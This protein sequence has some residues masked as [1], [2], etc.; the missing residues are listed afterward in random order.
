[1]TK[2]LFNPQF[3]SIFRT[4]HN[5]TY[6][7]RRLCRFSDIYMTSISCLLNYDLSYTFYPRRTPLQHEAPLWMDQLCTGCMKTPHLEEMSHIRWGLRLLSLTVTVRILYFTPGKDVTMPEDVFPYRTMSFLEK[8]VLHSS[9]RTK[10]RSRSTLWPTSPM[11]S[12]EGAVDLA[13][14]HRACYAGRL[15]CLGTRVILKLLPQ[16]RRRGNAEQHWAADAHFTA[17]K[18]LLSDK[19]VCWSLIEA[20]NWVT[21]SL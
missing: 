15:L 4:C 13:A 11:N 8:K 19:I 12:L 21:L 17:N 3:G 14:V 16:H 7:S 6:F 9:I 10:K 2:N 5:P 18:Y 1:M 20:L